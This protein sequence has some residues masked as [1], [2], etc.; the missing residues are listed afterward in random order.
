[1]F[2]VSGL[3]DLGI[4]RIARPEW[5][6]IPVLELATVVV[7]LA[8]KPDSWDDRHITWQV[9]HLEGTAFPGQGSNVV[10]G[11]HSYLGV[12]ASQPVLEGPFHALDRLRKGELIE[13][14]AGSSIFVYE[15]VEQRVVTPRDIWVVRPTKGDAL[16]LITCETWNPRQKSFDERRVVRSALV[17]VR[18]LS[19]EMTDSNGS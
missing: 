10:L 1:M 4:A 11:G 7:N 17:E 3:P 12:K 5:V 15:T 19:A 2:T 9:G 16:T 14:Y 13:V 6:V 18:T 8:R